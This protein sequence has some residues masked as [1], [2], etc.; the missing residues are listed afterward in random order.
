MNI[1]YNRCKEIIEKLN[2][3]FAD[4]ER[5]ANVEFPKNINY[6][7]NEYFIYMFYSCLLDYGVR[8]KIYHK[9]L[10]NTY[11][12]YPSIFCPKYVSQ[13]KENELNDIIVN[14]IHPRYPNLATKKWINLSNELL[15]YDNILNYLKTI[16]NIDGLSQ[17]IRSIKGYGQKT[18]GLLIRIISDSNICNFKE[19][20]NSIPIDRHD[21]EIS[22][23]TNIINVNS[24]SNS[25][26]SKLSDSYINVG[27]ELNINP[28][29]ID[30]YL[31][32][33]G[34]SFCNKKNCEE[35]PLNQLC[36]RNNR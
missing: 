31:W 3:Y 30:K 13:M 21:I 35:C 10:I 9:N 2:N 18:G 16:K 19:K 36:T 28:S 29:D 24:L 5:L 6:G 22:Y 8:S 33:L 1:D 23:L 17:F 14:N 15:K 11:E 34:N 26:I 4:K 7:T 12:K 20:V 32:E 25:E 27:K